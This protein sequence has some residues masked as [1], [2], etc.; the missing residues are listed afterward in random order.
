VRLALSL[1]STASSTAT[2]TLEKLEALVKK[3]AAKK[4][5]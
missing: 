1:P 5:A 2:W 3:L 4:K